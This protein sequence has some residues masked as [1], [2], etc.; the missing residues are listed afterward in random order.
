MSG[1]PETELAV[2]SISSTSSTDITKPILKET[3]IVVKPQWINLGRTIFELTLVLLTI[4]ILIWDVVIPIAIS[5]TYY[6]VN[7]EVPCD[8]RPHL[9]T[10]IWYNYQNFKNEF[11]PS[12]SVLVTIHVFFALMAFPSYFTQL[13]IIK[14]GSKAHK[15]CGVIILSIVT[16]LWTF[17]GVAAAIV[18]SERGFNPNKYKID[19]NPDAP[20]CR[21]IH[22][23]N[24]ATS[25]SFSLYL[26]F[27]YDGALLNENLMHGI[28]AQILCFPYTHSSIIATTS[29]DSVSNINDNYNYGKYKID[30]KPMFP[31]QI[32]HMMCLACLSISSIFLYI[33][34]T[35]TMIFILLYIDGEIEKEGN[36]LMLLVMLL[37]IILIPTINVGNLRFVQQLFYNWKHME[38]I[39]INYLHYHH[40][41]ALAT[42][43]FV[44]L[45][46][47]VANVVY[48][49]GEGIA[50]YCYVIFFIFMFFWWFGCMHKWK[51]CKKHNWKRC[52][53]VTLWNE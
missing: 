36:L 11:G 26:Q 53:C 46:T 25:F 39:D 6:G 38:L 27:V 9:D 49:L 47:F 17:G 50:G 30:I 20:P 10:P 43:G 21:H 13:F 22:N 4:L 37:Q 5:E 24:K 18:V 19:I 45:W 34:R 3:D 12:W 51:Q 52:A 28:A 14:R 2:N 31:L 41:G 35:G 40:G 48:G 44:V 7:I 16:I 29:I 15:I 32:W 8:A 33:C 42:A 23:P 1:S